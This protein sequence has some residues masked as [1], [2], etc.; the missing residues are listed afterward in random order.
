MSSKILTV[1]SVEFQMNTIIR[2]C[3]VMP[4]DLYAK[5]GHEGDDVFMCGHEYD[6]R[7]QTFKRI[8]DEFDDVSSLASS[9]VKVS[10]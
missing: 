8:A 7:H 10:L 3:F 9:I 1:S 6:F 5:A 2:H 4:P